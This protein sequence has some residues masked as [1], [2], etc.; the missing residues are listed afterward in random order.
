MFF[1]DIEKYFHEAISVNIRKN[2]SQFVT[3]EVEKEQKQDTNSVY[4]R[5]SFNLNGDVV[6]HLNRPIPKN[7]I[8][9]L[10]MFYR[11]WE[12]INLLNEFSKYA[13]LNSIK[14]YFL[15]PNLPKTVFNKN[16]GVI[17]RYAKDLTSK[18]K[19]QIL[20]KPEDFVFADSLFYDTY[21]H[22]NKQGIDQRTI[23]L[24]KI[25]KKYIVNGI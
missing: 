4:S 1:N 14:V 25:L 9:E 6:R 2:I 17:F 10:K 21:Y 8:I 13:R 11:K 22:L 18:L 16:K 24:I 7:R 23:L 5:S 12:G 3:Q 15:F 19:M 20:N